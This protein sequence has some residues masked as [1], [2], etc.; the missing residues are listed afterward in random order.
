MIKMIKS[1]TECQIIHTQKRALERYNLE[2][3]KEDIKNITKQIRTGDAFFIEKQS[4][5]RLMYAVNYQG[6]QMRVIYDSY[7]DNLATILPLQP[8]NSVKEKPEEKPKTLNN[9]INSWKRRGY[10]YA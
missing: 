10:A 4:N 5:R 6:A 2:L 8:K 1:K 7:R 3:E 9:L